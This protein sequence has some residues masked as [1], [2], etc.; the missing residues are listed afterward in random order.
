MAVLDCYGNPMG[1][2]VTIPLALD[3]LE[4]SHRDGLIRAAISQVLAIAAAHHAGAVVIED[5]DFLAA[6]VEGREQAGRRPSRGKRGRTFRRHVS[7]LPTAKLRD[8]LTQ[9]AYNAGVAVIA[10]DPAYTSKWGAQH[11]LDLLE[12]QH[13]QHSLT[14]H[15]AASVAIGR[16]GLG[17]RLRRRATSARTPPVDGERATASASEGGAAEPATSRELEPRNGTRRPSDDRTRRSRSD[18]CK[19]TMPISAAE[20]SQEAQDRSGSP[21]EQDSLLLRV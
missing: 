20:V 2:P 13:R 9:M 3:G 16:R 4:A 1:V 17:Q 14:G 5:L 12:A 11:W 15:H 8:R 10:V 7:G 19:T 18:G 6:R 21:V